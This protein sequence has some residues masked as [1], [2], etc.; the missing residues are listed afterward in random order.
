MFRVFALAV[1]ALLAPLKGGGVMFVAKQIFLGRCA[2]AAWQNPYVTDGLVAQ[3]DGEWNAGGGVHDAAAKTW[4]DLSG[5]GNDCTLSQWATWTDNGI[6]CDGS[7][8]AAMAPS[9]G[10]ED[11]WYC[12]I[13]YD[14]VLTTYG[15]FCYFTTHSIG[16]SQNSSPFQ[17]SFKGS[18]VML[19]NGSVIKD[20]A[21]VSSYYDNIPLKASMSVDFFNVKLRIN[22]VDQLAS[23]G[24]ENWSQTTIGEIG[25]RAART[26]NVYKGT[27]N[28]IR[29]Y[30]RAPTAEE[31]A[32]NYAID[33][34]RFKLP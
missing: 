34:E 27:I 13:V 12:E 16:S 21:Y 33:K 8:Y 32:A 17:I 11:T 22:N 28:S 7:H 10:I 18:A 25:G 5:N 9:A 6:V 4:K 30:S 29:L 19:N 26:S 2:K 3:Y 23:S 31:I 15:Y 1:L 14:R 24:Y 20:G